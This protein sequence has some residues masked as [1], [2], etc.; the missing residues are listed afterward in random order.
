MRLVHGFLIVRFPGLRRAQLDHF[1]RVFMDQE[2]V[3]IRV[4]FLL[5]AVMRCLF[6]GLRRALTATLGTV[7]GPRGGTLQHE[8][9]GGDPA[10]VP[11]WC[12]VERGSGAS[13]DRQQA[14]N[15]VVRLG[16]AQ[17]KVQAVHGL[18]RIGLLIDEDKKQL[19]VHL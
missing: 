5:P 14:M 1:A 3:L 19:V 18:Q 11:F 4:C 2:H 16:L 8:G 6:R 17:P 12:Q 10:G 15:P 9:T 7:Q 13:Q